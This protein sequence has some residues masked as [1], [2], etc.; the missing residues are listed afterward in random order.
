MVSVSFHLIRSTARSISAPARN[1]SN[2]LPAEARK[3]IQTVVCISKRFPPATP[4]AYLDERDRDAQSDRDQAREQCHP[5]PQG[6][7]RPDLLHPDLMR[8]TLLED[9]PPTGTR[10]RKTRSLDT[11]MTDFGLLSNQSPEF[12]LQSTPDLTGCPDQRLSRRSKSYAIVR[13]KA[14]GHRCR[15]GRAVGHRSWEVIANRCHDHMFFPPRL[16]TV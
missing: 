1:V 14:D 2:M 4:Q 7:Y 11:K 10:G 9:N 16:Y 5:D 15:D 12:I 6:C 13:P 3:L 8:S